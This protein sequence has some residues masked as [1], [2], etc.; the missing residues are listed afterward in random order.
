[1]KNDALRKKVANYKHHAITRGNY[2]AYAHDQHY[3]SLPACIVPIS[4]WRRFLKPFDYCTVPGQ[5]SEGY[6]IA[7][8]V[9]KLPSNYPRV[10]LFHYF[11]SFE[12]VPSLINRCQMWSLAGGKL[13][14]LFRVYRH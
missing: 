11:A 12:S 5:F 3:R 8:W 2:K 14:F 9:A 6:H 1:M 13:G 4:N 10:I 7:V